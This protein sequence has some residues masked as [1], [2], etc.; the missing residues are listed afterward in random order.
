MKELI[1]DNRKAVIN[2]M[3]LQ[4]F[5]ISGDKRSK[6]ISV[7]PEVLLSSHKTIVTGA[8]KWLDKGVVSRA[9]KNG[10]QPITIH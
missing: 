4:L 6:W 9:I 7:W 8:S 2:G 1:N 3:T 5:R 10:K